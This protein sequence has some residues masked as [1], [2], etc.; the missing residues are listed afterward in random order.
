MPAAENLAYAAGLYGLTPR[1]ARVRIAEVLDRVGF[2]AER[3]SAPM[4]SLSR[5]T[6]QRWRWR[7]LLTSP[8]PLLLDEPTT[9]LDPRSRLIGAVMWSSLGILLEILTDTPL[10]LK[11]RNYS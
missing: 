10:A 5:G 2:P 11:I 4:E 8:V 9:G 3:R 1:D 6:Q 7:A